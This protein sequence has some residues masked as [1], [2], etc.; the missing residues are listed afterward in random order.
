[1]WNDLTSNDR[2]V[3]CEFSHFS[4]NVKEV[5]PAAERFFCPPFPRRAVPL[6]AN[7]PNMLQGGVWTRKRRNLIARTQSK[8]P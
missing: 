1:M 4:P 5:L 3:R 2:E 7:P 8:N 6:R